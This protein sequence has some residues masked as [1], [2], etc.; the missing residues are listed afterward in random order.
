MAFYNK[1]L[2][3]FFPRSLKEHA[4]QSYCFHEYNILL[5]EHAF[6]CF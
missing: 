3:N 4:F 6:Q 2:N 1:L 5:K